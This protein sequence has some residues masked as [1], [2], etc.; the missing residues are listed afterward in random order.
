MNTGDRIAAAVV[1]I[2]KS[3]AAV[4]PGPGGQYV[5]MDMDRAGRRYDRGQANLIQLFI[6][7][8]IAT[9]VGVGVVI[10][11]MND[12][13]ETVTFQNPMTQTVIEYVPLFI[14]L[15]LL[16]GVAAPIMRSL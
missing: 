9:I 15:L 2:G 12:Q 8:T 3:V 16:V 6:G 4:L 13:I 10:P 7:I 11:L 1:T 14:G 5:Q